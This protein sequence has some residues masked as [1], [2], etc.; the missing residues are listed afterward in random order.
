MNSSRF[1][2]LAAAAALS[3]ATLT[4]CGSSTPRVEAKGLASYSTRGPVT[5]VDVRDRNAYDRAHLPGAT[6]MEN[7]V[8][9]EELNEKSKDQPVVVY[10]NGE[11]GRDEEMAA[12]ALGKAGFKNVSILK[13]GMAAYA[14][15]K[16][17]T[18]SKEEEER[19]AEMVEQAIKNASERV[20]D[21]KRMEKTMKKALDE[22]FKKKSE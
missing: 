10:G 6:L 3:L 17:P 19:A 5:A 22:A 14:A 12:E 15:L 21:Q 13:G 9:P 1:A 18:R 8:V 7:W 20:E 4:G 2:A 16:L 11:E